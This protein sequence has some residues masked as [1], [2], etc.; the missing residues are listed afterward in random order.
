[1]QQHARDQERFV[2][3]RDELVAEARRWHTQLQ[4]LQSLSPV[5]NCE[6]PASPMASSGRKSRPGGS[7]MSAQHS[8]S[9]ESLCSHD[10]SSDLEPRTDAPKAL[11]P[12]FALALPRASAPAVETSDDASAAAGSVMDGGMAEAKVERSESLVDV[13]QTAIRSQAKVI[14]LFAKLKQTEAELVTC[15]RDQ[16]ELTQALEEQQAIADELASANHEAHVVRNERAQLAATV[17]GLESSLQLADLKIEAVESENE[18]LHNEAMRLQAANTELRKQQSALLAEIEKLESAS[19]RKDPVRARMVGE[20]SEPRSVASTCTPGCAF[21]AKFQDACARESWQEERV[22]DLTNELCDLRESLTLRDWKIDHLTEQLSRLPQSSSPARTELTLPQHATPQ[23]ASE[24]HGSPQRDSS[25]APLNVLWHQ[26][27]PADP[28]APHSHSSGDRAAMHHAAEPMGHLP[29]GSQIPPEKS[30]VAILEEV[31][32]IQQELS[33]AL[34]E[35]D[36]VFARHRS[37]RNPFEHP[38]AHSFFVVDPVA[39]VLQLR[40][41]NELIARELSAKQESFRQLERKCEAM[42]REFTIGTG[43]AVSSSGAHL[44]SELND[45]HSLLAVKEDEIDGLRHQLDQTELAKQELCIALEDC[46]TRLETSESEKCGLSSELEETTRESHALADVLEKA[47]NDIQ[48]L[49]RRCDESERECEQAHVQ[50]GELTRSRC[51]SKPSCVDVSCQTSDSWRRSARTAETLAY[52]FGQQD[53]KIKLGGSGTSDVW[54]R[55]LG[56]VLRARLETA[57]ISVEVDSL[58]PLPGTDKLVSASNSRRARLKA[59]ENRQQLN[60][61]G[62]IHT[63]V[64]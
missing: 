46:A 31:G 20:L 16:L 47:L 29:L 64:A 13:R 10:D 11:S 61:N 42:T 30:G 7:P 35:N 3:E 52:P 43:S 4:Q 38:R 6:S 49:Q 28:P 40:G 25:L 62:S 57:W 36:N 18:E 23:H 32:R 48:T 14:Q 54:E 63:E 41:K 5:P 26:P 33:N 45:A 24:Q 9:L 8:F 56:L 21:Y 50:I 39:P 15:R 37:T 27:L 51:Q 34:G 17:E 59:L 53:A 2:K 55:T 58:G 12:S 19:F 1:M 44:L 60:E 22:C